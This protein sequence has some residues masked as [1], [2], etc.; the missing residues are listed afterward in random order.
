MFGQL[1]LSSVGMGQ[2]LDQW[3]SEVRAGWCIRHLYMLTCRLL[4]HL[5]MTSSN[6]DASSHGDGRS[7]IS[8]FPAIPQEVIPSASNSRVMEQGEQGIS[9]LPTLVADVDG[10]EVKLSGVTDIMNFF[11][12]K[13]SIETS[14]KS[15]E[16]QSDELQAEDTLS[17]ITNQLLGILSYL[18][19]ILRSGRGSKVCTAA[20]AAT[21]TTLSPPRPTQPLI[22]Y[23]YEG[24]QFCRL[25]REVLTELDIVYELRSC[26]KGSPRR[27][28][29]AEITGGSSQCP[30]LVDPNCDVKMAESKDIVGKYSMIS[31]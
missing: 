15:K 14:S 10:V 4:S 17:Q 20:T 3:R 2:C 5:T 11:D 29:L 31:P 28:E 30:F 19:G 7:L 24:N 16:Q 21:S 27:E 18:P 6:H 8:P 13:F 1:Q 25:V 26:G 12:D 9:V 22:L 23:S